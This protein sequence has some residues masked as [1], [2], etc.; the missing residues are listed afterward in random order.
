V[1]R[2]RLLAASSRLLALA[3]RERVARCRRLIGRRRMIS[4]GSDAELRETVRRRLLDGRLKAAT[5]R[6]WPAPRATGLSC[7]VCGLRIVEPDVDYLIS[8]AERGHAHIECYNV[9]VEESAAL[10]IAAP[11]RPEVPENGR[12]MRAAGRR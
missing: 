2:S 6:C 5:W 11:V 1:S 8:A 4:G 7:L 10:G 3:S 12:V 9:W